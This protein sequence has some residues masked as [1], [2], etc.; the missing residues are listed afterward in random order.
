MIGV[1][2]QD[3]SCI[4]PSFSIVDRSGGEVLKITGPTC[5]SFCSIVMCCDARFGISESANGSPVGNIQKNFSVKEL[6]TDANNFGFTVRP[7]LDVRLKAL[8]L[9]SVFSIV[10]LFCRIAL[11]QQFFH[12][13]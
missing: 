3:C 9:A 8:L 2:A 1:V 12:G 13:G 7:D 6:F 5:G 4:S 10:S 11:K